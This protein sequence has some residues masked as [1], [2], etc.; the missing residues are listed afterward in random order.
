[1]TVRYRGASSSVHSLPSGCAQGD[2]VGM[3][4]F[5]VQMSDLAMDPVHF[6]SSQTGD[7]LA[8][9]APPPPAETPT[10][11]RAKWIDDTSLAE[12]VILDKM[13]TKEKDD[14][15]GLRNYHDRHGWSLQTDRL[16]L[17][18]RLTQIRQYVKTH[19]MSVNYKKTK[20]IPF[21]F[22]RKYDFEPRVE[23]DGQILDIEYTAKLLGVIID[24]SGRWN[25]HIEYITNKA[26]QRVYF[27]KRLKHL[28][29][30]EDTLKQIYFLFIRSILEFAAP[31]W[32]G[33]LIVNKKL[34]NMI[35][36]VQRYV[37]R[38]IRPDLTPDQT[39]KE[40]NILSLESRRIAITRRFANRMVKNTN[41]AYLFQRN[42]REA[43]MS[44]GKIIEP[45]WKRKRYGF[46]SIPFFIRLINEG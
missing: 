35:A 33:A 31:V 18:E 20:V 11:I 28:G 32:T 27:L 26:K 21:N 9:P 41:F 5:L 30:S 36:K 16:A 4:L 43:S 3:I 13:L 7:T 29:A 42:K 12:S 23:Y 24:S 8:V 38:V 34:T 40:L 45:T 1:M 17:Q 14:F 6:A 25:K 10:E 39:E 37:C 46:S 2:V 44:F 15:I 19:D 22:S